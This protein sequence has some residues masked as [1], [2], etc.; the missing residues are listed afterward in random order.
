VRNLSAYGANIITTEKW[1][2]GTV[3][4]LTLQ[5]GAHVNGP[6]DEVGSPAVSVRT[7]VVSQ[8]A[9]NVRVV[10]VCLNKQERHAMRRFLQDIQ[11]AE[12]TVT[13]RRMSAA[14]GQSL[15]EFALILPLVLLLVVNVVN[16]GS[17]LYTWITVSN[18]ARAGAQYMI[19]SSAS[20]GYPRDATAAQITTL[21]QNDLGS[22]IGS[23][24]T[25]NVCTNNNGVYHPIAA[26]SGACA[27]ANN[28]DGFS[29][30]E[31]LYVL[32][33]VDVTYTWRPPIPLWNF[34]KLGIHATLPYTTIHRTAVMRMIQ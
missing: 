12:A 13:P 27:S 2:P 33:T 32:A 25:I 19:L 3:I 20:V 1:F 31:S 7:R 16:F 4:Q 8:D 14:S 30:P 9:D 24:A 11:R 34:P 6:G 26:G 23:N 5:H 10:F 28:T 15:I 29:D 17:F 22:T 18:A 21:V